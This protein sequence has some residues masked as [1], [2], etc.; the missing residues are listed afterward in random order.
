M[1]LI[2]AFFGGTGDRA[3]F[4]LTAITIR[5]QTFKANKHIDTREQSIQICG[6]ELERLKDKAWMLPVFPMLH[7]HISTVAQTRQTAH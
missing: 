3:A 4:Q 2:E 1:L 5:S 6:S 7:R